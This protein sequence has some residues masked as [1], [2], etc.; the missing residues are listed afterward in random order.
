MNVKRPAPRDSFWGLCCFGCVSEWM[1]AHKSALE[2]SLQDLRSA[3]RGV[4]GVQ[5]LSEK[6]LW[7]LALES[8]N[9]SFLC[10]GNFQSKTQQLFHKTRFT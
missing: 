8:R 2:S 1:L 7:Y 10:V 4:T 9:L 3:V 5:V 6:A